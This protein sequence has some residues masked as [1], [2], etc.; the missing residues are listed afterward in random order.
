MKK[1][2]GWWCSTINQFT[3][4]RECEGCAKPCYIEVE[5]KENFLGPAGEVLKRV[6]GEKNDAS[7]GSNSRGVAADIS[8]GQVMS[9]AITDRDI[10]EA[11]VRIGT[12]YLMT[13][14]DAVVQDCIKQARAVAAAVKGS[15]K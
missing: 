7:T 2:V 12:A 3:I 1:Q 6:L 10:F 4:K 5:E 11:A 9:K 15:A 8:S 13:G 14:R